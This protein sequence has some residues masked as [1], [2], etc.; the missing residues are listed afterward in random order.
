MMYFGNREKMRW[1][2]APA[3]GAGFSAIGY[4]DTVEFT[5]GGMGARNSVNAHMEYD[6]SWGSLT[7]DEIAQIEDYAYGLYTSKNGL[8]YWLDP[9]A[10]DRNL[11]NRAWAAPKIT[12]ED[13]VPFTGGKRPSLQYIGDTSLDY[14]A[15][16]ASYTVDAGQV[17]RKFYCPIPPGYTAWLGAHGAAQAQGL[18]VQP[19][20][21][22]T[23]VGSLVPVPVTSVSTLDRFSN[24]FSSPSYDGIDITLDTSAAGTIVLA[25]LMLQV[26]PDGET[27]A[28]GG[29]LS[30]RGNS[31]CVFAGKPKVM[32]YSIPGASVG[33]TA[34]IV[35][36]GDWL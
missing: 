19:T 13:G 21:A 11:F 1:V 29:F 17:S 33:M 25:G 27:P 31:G 22:G 30:G 6:L 9:T 16:A 4:T 2:K 24:A 20:L 15:Y 28:Q 5:S 35:E 10:M 12:A 14:P 7:L 3:P 26:L 32:P 18:L 36:V 23:P 8:I 34:R